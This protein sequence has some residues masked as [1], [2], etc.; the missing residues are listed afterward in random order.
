MAHEL[1]HYESMSVRTLKFL[2]LVALLATACSGEFNTRTG[3]GQSPT[4]GA[5]AGA[6]GATGSEFFRINVLPLLS[7]PRPKGACALCH[8]GADPVNGPDFLGAN[9]GTNYTTLLASPNVVGTTPGTSSLY[10]RG[11]HTGDAFTPTE[12]AL[13]GE[14][15]ELEN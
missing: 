3:L 8:Q 10:T 12:L 11:A 9:A 15:I 2:P 4:G 7:A 5:D 14:W 13:V 1:L 6:Q